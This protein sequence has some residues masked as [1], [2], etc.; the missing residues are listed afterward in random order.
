MRY[1]IIE[2]TA[3]LRPFVRHFWILDIT[4][5]DLPYAQHLTPYGRL[6][7][8]FYLNQP[9]LGYSEEINAVNRTDGI[10][11]GFFEESILLNHF[12]PFRA[13]GISFQPWAGG[14]IFQIPAN[15]F[16][17]KST[18]F[19][20][21]DKHSTLR[22]ELLEATTEVEII[23]NFEK[24]LLQKVSALE[25]DK[26]AAFIT[27]EILKNPMDNML[28]DTIIPQ[29]GLSKRRIQQRFLSSVGVTMG[30]YNSISRFEKSLELMAV[31]QHPT[32]TEIGFHAGYYDQ[33]HFI[34]EF[35]RFAKATPSAF[36]KGI[37]AKD[38]VEKS[39][40]LN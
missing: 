26:V 27:S 2:P 19:S 10:F 20:D 1:K 6:E 34:R 35:K 13:A 14:E 40:I 4:K 38:Q 9:I 15:H 33:S 37:A 30:F 12:A 31:E 24:Y 32:L 29:I 3:S 36:A 23:Q 7:L 22:N 5:D 39:F 18:E 28:H 16:C 8:F 11:T 21:I 25:V 17:N